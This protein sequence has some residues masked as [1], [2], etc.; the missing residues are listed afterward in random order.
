MDLGAVGLELRFDLWKVRIQ[1]L[2]DVLFDFAGDLAETIRIRELVEEHLRPL[3]VRG[4]GTQ[5]NRR[6]FVRCEFGGEDVE[7][8]NGH[9]RES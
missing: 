5:V 9:E 2:D 8:L 7:R 6:A 1:I 3:L 4:L